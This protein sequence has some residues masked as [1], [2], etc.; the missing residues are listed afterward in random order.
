MDASE[1]VIYR[2]FKMNVCIRIFSPRLVRLSEARV[3]VNE[4][5]LLLRVLYGAYTRSALCER[6]I[7]VWDFWGKTRAKLLHPGSDV[8]KRSMSCVIGCN[9][10]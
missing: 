5:E 7:R 10:L 8:N 6:A 9:R 2:G 3:D 1:T 4:A